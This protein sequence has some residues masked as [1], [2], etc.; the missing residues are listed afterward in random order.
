M[1][2][3]NAIFNEHKIGK[4][5]DFQIIEKFIEEKDQKDFISMMDSLESNDQLTIIGDGRKVLI[6]PSE[7][8]IKYFIKKYSNKVKE[9]F[10]HLMIHQLLVGKYE[11]G[12]SMVVHRD[13]DSHQQCED[14]EVSGVLY[15]NDNYVGGEI[16]FPNI[17][18]QYLPSSGSIVL[19]GIHDTDYDHGVKTIESGVKYV[20]PMCFTNNKKYLNKEYDWDSLINKLKMPD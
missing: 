3:K 2:Y 17:G 4:T 8:N 7:L 9:L 11:K 12:A 13:S 19:F 14:C 10:P 15:F 16:Y 20:M 18:K 5:I 6:N 1:E